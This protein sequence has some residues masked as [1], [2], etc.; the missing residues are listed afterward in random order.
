MCQGHLINPVDMT[1]E[2]MINH[3]AKNAEEIVG[4]NKNFPAHH[5]WCFTRHAQASYVAATLEMVGMED[6]EDS[7]H[8]HI[9]PELSGGITTL[10]V[11]IPGGSKLLCSNGHTLID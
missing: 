10:T 4:F 11:V 3:H 8:K 6:S 2:Q 5:R 1:I 9:H 7:I